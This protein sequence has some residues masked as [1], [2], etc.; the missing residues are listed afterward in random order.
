MNKTLLST[1]CATLV[2]SAGLTMVTGAQA[3]EF[4]TVVSKAPA[5]TQVAV[6][7][8]QCVSQEQIVRQT[9]TGA[10]SLIGAVVG[11]SIGNAMGGG[12]GRAATTGV[13]VLAGALI[14]NRIEADAAP[15]TAAT[16]QQCQVVSRIE[17][18]QVGYDVLYDYNGQRYSARVPTDPGSPGALLALNV[19][20]TAAGA[21]PVAVDAAPPVAYAP[22]TVVY[23]GP[24]MAYGPVVYGPPVYVGPTVGLSI[25]TGWGRGWGY[26][27]WH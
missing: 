11:G 23:S 10:G 17:T 13:G 9:P 24:P 19:S 6:P 20:V 18:R 27:R 21:V 16:V 3:A 2:A 25:G 1:A 26:G 4:G 8:N 14:G 7:Q 22:A 15:T 12:A 5:Y